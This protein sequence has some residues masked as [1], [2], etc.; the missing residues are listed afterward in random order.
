MRV[1]NGT[2]AQIWQ[3]VFGENQL[4][5]LDP[6]PERL[7]NKETPRPDAEGRAQEGRRQADPDADREENLRKG[8][9]K[10]Q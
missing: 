4:W 10:N 1:D 7:L 2:Q 5:K 8:C 9:K 3:D 6:V